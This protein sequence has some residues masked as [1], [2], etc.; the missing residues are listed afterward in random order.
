MTT[1][2]G[3]MS[4]LL[5]V[6]I[7]ARTA[8]TQQESVTPATPAPTPPSTT[9]APTTS[10]PPPVTESATESMPVATT[11]ETA[12]SLSRATM[13]SPPS[14]IPSSTSSQFFAGCDPDGWLYLGR[15]TGNAWESAL[16][17]NQQLRQPAIASNGV[18][19][20]EVDVDLISGAVGATAE[21]CSD[22]RVGPV[23]SPKPGA[24]ADPGRWYRAIA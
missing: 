22:G 12:D 9:T 1:C 14:G 13:P 19:I 8:C 5:H 7:L 3:R 18:L 4:L 6:L 16:D 11:A 20:H 17:E 21:A 15:W 23:I 10:I 2:L 24:L